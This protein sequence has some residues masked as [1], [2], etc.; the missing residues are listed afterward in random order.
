[1]RIKLWRCWF[2]WKGVAFTFDDKLVK[3]FLS[4]FIWWYIGREVK[5]C[6]TTS[7]WITFRRLD[8][9]QLILVFFIQILLS[10]V[11]FFFQ[12]MQSHYKHNGINT[13]SLTRI[14]LTHPLTYS[15]HL[16]FVNFN[17][18]FFSMLYLHICLWIIFKWH[19][20]W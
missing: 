20:P 12:F 14:I 3:L 18:G 2:C 5:D 13:N 6:K 1:M 7:I 17:L 8:T 16:R 9:I 10:Y 19:I 15:Y 4:S 11:Y